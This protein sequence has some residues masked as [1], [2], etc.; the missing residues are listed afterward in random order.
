M[1]DIWNPWHGCKKV[2]EG[3]A[4]CYMYFL[5]KM[6]DQNGANIYRTKNGFDYPLQKNRH[7]AYKIQSGETVRVCMTSDFFLAEADPWRE[8]AWS[9]IWQRPDVKFLLL[10]KRP[11]RVAACLPHDWGQ[12]WENVFFNVTCENQRRA[13]ERLPLLLQ[14][15][16]KHKGVF[17]APFIGPVSL[18]K[19]LASGQIEQVTCGGENY[20]GARPCDFA[21]VKNL[22][23]ECAAYNVSFYF[24]ETGTRFIKDG[25]EYFIPNKQVQ[26]HQ[27]HKAG[28]NVRGRLAPYKLC[29]GFGRPISQARLHQPRFGPQC[30]GCGSRPICNGC[31]NC[32]RCTAQAN[33][34]DPA[35]PPSGQLT[36]QNK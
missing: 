35:N 1:H 4:N 30:Q 36:F 18:G 22:S 10:T 24:F 19:Y 17:C 11:E 9:I 13:D 6:R 21:W 34:A 2:S 26:S 32:G 20:D 5:D 14:L 15:P 33:Q 7:G 16:F 29:D 23:R 31:A 8:E 3:C 25:R 28:V 12:G 27:A